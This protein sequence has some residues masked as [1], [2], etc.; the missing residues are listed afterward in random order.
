MKKNLLGTHVSTAGGFYKSA[1]MGMEIGCT[2][3]QIFT[4]SNRQWRAKDIQEEDVLMFRQHLASCKI[5]YVAA[6]ASYLINICSPDIN[7][8]AKSISALKIEVERCFKLGIKDLVLHP[9]SKK[10]MSEELALEQA[11]KNINTVL[12]ST[13]GTR[14]LLETMAGQGSSVGHKF[15]QLA[16]IISKVEQQ[17]RIGVC[18]DTC[19]AFA[20]GYDF[21]TINKY[22]DM[23]DHFDNVVG[24]EKLGLIHL[25]DSKKELGSKV[26]RH[27]HIGK[28][29][30]GVIA[31]KAIMN[32]LRL[33]RVPKI[34]ETPKE[35]DLKEDQRNLF[36]LINLL[37]KENL[38]YLTDTNLI[39]NLV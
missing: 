5:Q 28:G 16:K 32:D 36:F 24:L 10:H 22:N 2:A 26:D 35:G 38:K 21:S 3:I 31:F 20:A 37:K 13:T 27:E 29:E 4:K 23:W 34:L 9:G 6:H 18:F 7:T 39:K 17:D 11:S 19:H 33:I 15:E 12:E 25:N 1:I 8:Q 14:I 30:I